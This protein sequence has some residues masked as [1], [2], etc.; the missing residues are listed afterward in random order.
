MTFME[1]VLDGLRLVLVWPAPGY[2]LLGVAIGMF[3][4]AVPGLGGLVGMA[5]LLPFTFGMEPQIAFAFILG[6]YAVTTTAD[7]LASV[8]LGSPGTAASQ[9][10]ILDGYPMAQKGQAS[11]RT[12]NARTIQTC[13]RRGRRRRDVNGSNG[14]RLDAT[15]AGLGVPREEGDFQRLRVARYP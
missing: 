14:R 13:G 3:F 6:M 12:H 10:T 8:L 2:M 9:A 15:G 4:G 5:I 1:A 11:G 7:T